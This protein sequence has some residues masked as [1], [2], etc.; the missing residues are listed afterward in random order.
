MTLQDPFSTFSNL[1]KT[2]KCQYFQYGWRGNNIIIVSLSLLYF[3]KLHAAF[4]LQAYLKWYALFIPTVLCHYI[5]HPHVISPICPL[6]LP[7]F[8]FITASLASPVIDL[9][10]SNKVKP[11]FQ[12]SLNSHVRWVMQAAD[13]KSFLSIS[14]RLTHERASFVEVHLAQRSIPKQK[15][16]MN[17]LWMD[18]SASLPNCHHAAPQSKHLPFGCFINAPRAASRRTVGNLGSHPSPSSLTT[19]QTLL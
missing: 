3:I 1:E 14:Q 9:Q 15:I 4:E 18:W 17:R 7:C 8:R 13:Y 2:E 12:R 10:Q 6:F 19:A 11:D 5:G 16:F